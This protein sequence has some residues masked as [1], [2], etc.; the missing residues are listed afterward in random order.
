MRTV[1]KYCYSPD[2]KDKKLF[3]CD[4]CK[5]KNSQKGTM[6]N[7]KT[8]SCSFCGK[9]NGILKDVGNG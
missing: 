8:A 2:C 3:K 9:N 4:E 1:H 5:K 7:E 6:K